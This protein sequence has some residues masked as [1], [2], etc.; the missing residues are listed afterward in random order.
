MR[1][2]AHVSPLAGSWQGPAATSG[3]HDDD[4]PRAG[5]GPP[6]PPPQ[7][8]QEAIAD[9]EEECA[10]NFVD[11]PSESDDDNESVEQEE[12]PLVL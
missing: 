1:R 3:S 7:Q 6:P 12:Y 4:A 11:S 10:F 5:A 8:Q 2:G 9:E